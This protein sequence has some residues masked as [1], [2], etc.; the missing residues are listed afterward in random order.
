MRS[1]VLTVVGL[2]IVAI[3]VTAAFAASEFIPH[4]EVVGW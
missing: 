1:L 4:Q 2:V 3:A